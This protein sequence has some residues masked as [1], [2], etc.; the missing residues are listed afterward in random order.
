M[1][2]KRVGTVRVAVVAAAF[3][4][5]T[6]LVRMGAFTSADQFAL[7]HLMPG[8]EFQPRG[9]QFLA[10]VV[11]FLR[12]GPSDHT[13]QE[14]ADA[15]ILPAALPVSLVGMFVIAGFVA[16]GRGGI[17]G[18]AAYSGAYVISIA[19]EGGFKFLVSR[20]ALFALSHG[21]SIPARNF[22]SSYPSGHAVRAVIAAAAASAAWPRARRIFALWAVSACAMLEIGGFHTPSDVVGGLLL[23]VLLVESGEAITATTFARDRASHVAEQT[24]ARLPYARR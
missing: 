16:I 1:R 5:L 4:T 13:I 15:F 11:P 9:A 12:G 24:R 18:A 14:V 22:E 20:P 21:H 3:V 19:L 10:G 23:G 7:N 17:A 8:F 6:I 2:L